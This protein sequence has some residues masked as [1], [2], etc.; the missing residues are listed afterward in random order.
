MEKVRADKD[1]LN[2]PHS[3]QVMESLKSVSLEK[4]RRYI[5]QPPLVD[6]LSKKHGIPKEKIF[7]ENGIIGL[8]HRVFDC[9]LT[10]KSKVLLPELGYPYYH[11]LAKHHSAKIG[12]FRFMRTDG[13]F[14]YD[15]ADIL[16]RIKDQP[17][18]VV[19]IDP[20]SPLGFSIPEEKL[21]T[22][23]KAI[24]PEILVVLDQAHEGF[25]I[26]HVKDVRELIEDHP[27]LLV[28]RGFSK[29]YGMAGLRIAYALCGTRVMTMIN[30]KERYLGFDNV[31]QEIAVAALNSEE[32]Y[33]KNANEIRREKER[34]IEAVK[35]L[36]EYKIYKT[37]TL[38]LVI[39]VPESQKALI[40]RQAHNAG[41]MLRY[42][43][44][45]H[46]NLRNMY[47][48]TMGPED[49]TD[50]LV[51]LFN[52]VS[53]LCDFNITNSDAKQ[54]INTRDE[55]YTVNR[56]EVPCK[57]SNLLMGM[58]KVLLPPGGKVSPHY[59]KEQDEVFEF[60]SKAYFVLNGQEFEVKAGDLVNIKPGDKHEIRALK[61]KFARIVC[62]RFPYSL[63]DKYL[64]S[65]E[66]IIHEES[67]V[68]AEI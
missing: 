34:F 14:E 23:L 51:D 62:L 40:D 19:L 50:R 31:A 47:R 20:E 43:E 10:E 67:D 3:R 21:R 65:G 59:H 17:E 9:C 7:L 5:K 45:Y 33:A 55:G 49:H 1:E 26:E 58:M 39:E 57:K 25:R 2:F 18:I 15:V 28:A 41:V 35:D 66:Q 63:S 64:P 56:F 13:G 52:S 4:L 29:F 24:N 11:E 37:D 8:I 61:D 27:N 60:H 54:K 12:F 44:D 38:S 36:N 22:I 16:D 68:N 42:L 6:L 32:H 30:F 48:I 53:W 46:V